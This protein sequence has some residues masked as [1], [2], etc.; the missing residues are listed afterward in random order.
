[1]KKYSVH[2]KAL[3]LQTFWLLFL[4][5]LCRLLFIYSNRS[6]LE[7]STLK[8]FFIILLGGLRFDISAISATN[9]LFIILSLIPFSFVGKKQYKNFLALLFVVVNSICLLANMVDVAYFPFVHKRSQADSLLFISGEKGND[10]FRLL[11]SF[12]LQYW[13]LVVVFFILIFILW[14]GFKHTQNI[15]HNNYSSIQEYFFS[16]VIFFSVIALTVIGIRGGLQEKPLDIIH[17]S[18]MAEAK[19]IPALLNTPFSIMKSLD[20]KSL[21]DRKY[22]TEDIIQNS[23]HNGIHKPLSQEPFKKQNVV[24]IIVEGLSSKYIGYFGGKA[25][26]PFLDSLFTESLVFTNAFANAKESIQGIPA[27]LSSIPSWQ[28]D[29]FIFSP[30]ASNKITSLPSILKK[31]GYQTSFFHGGFNGTMGFD[32]YSKL[33]GFDSY[34]GKNEYNNN[35]DYDGFWG[36]W[37]EPF[38]QAMAN[39]LSAT[40]QP[41]FSSV[42]TLNTHHPFIVP[43]QYKNIFNKH[44]QPL[45]NCF[46]YL[47][48]SL[49]KF[50][51]TIKQT[52]WF[53][54]TLF[55]ITADHTAPNI[56]GEKAS[57]SMEDFRI[58]LIFYQPNNK[59][60]KGTNH[61]IANQIDILP[62][63]L[64]F[65]HYP[66]AYF[67]LGESLF[68]STTHKNSISYSGNVYQFINSNFCYLFNG[69]SPVAFYNWKLDSTLSNNLYTTKMNLDMLTC[70]SLLKKKVQFFNES[71]IKNKMNTETIGI[72]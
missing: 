65:L 38:L 56:N 10:F 20:K 42:F 14:K 51:E 30:F 66:K 64:H 62:S 19:N 58:P 39:K 37:D 16:T 5:S 11:P 33:A 72:K 70:D 3:F 49:L 40:K 18:E 2:L 61:I 13:Y 60:L 68:D 36:I 57:T 26:T 47:D 54:N 48:Y 17:A 15:P 27:I 29:P 35:T 23:F 43:P 22:F 34:F 45:L 52:S 4:Y 46:E 8:T 9:S 69:E 31:E 53:N 1:M 32:S 21:I 6:E 67:S 7:I 24:V 41:F 28:S 12:L 71:M 59:E 63:V 44:K 25:N 55:V 50:F